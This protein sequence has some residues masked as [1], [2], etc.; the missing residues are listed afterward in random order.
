[1]SLV[2]RR[3]TRTVDIRGPENVGNNG[4][5][6]TS[7]EDRMS[8]GGDRVIVATADSGDI[9]GVVVGGETLAASSL[10]C[11]DDDGSGARLFF[12]FTSVIATDV[13]DASPVADAWVGVDGR[14]VA[15]PPRML[16]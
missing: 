2:V 6:E 7:D 9:L 1:M 15:L 16:S 11:D 4:L 3:H 10:A 14:P 13:E 12:F 8:C 5:D